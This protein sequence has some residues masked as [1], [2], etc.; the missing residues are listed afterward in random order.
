MKSFGD[1]RASLDSI[2]NSWTGPHQWLLSHCH[3]LTGHCGKKCRHMFLLPKQAH[4]APGRKDR[5]FFIWKEDG[6]R[7]V[8]GP[9]KAPGIN[10]ASR[11]HPLSL[12]VITSKP[13][14]IHMVVH[15]K[16]RRLPVCPVVS[17]IRAR[18]AGRGYRQNRAPGR[19]SPP[20]CRPGDS[21]APASLRSKPPSGIKTRG[22]RISS[23]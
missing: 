6:I 14:I 20:P 12:S 3:G 19:G 16:R 9:T 2:R 18:G 8:Q 21:F 10:A 4:W 1:W 5:N 11:L 15:N 17:A 23:A 22:R 7:C 13:P